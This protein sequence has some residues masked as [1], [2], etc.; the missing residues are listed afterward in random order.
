MGCSIH[1]LFLANLGPPAQ[2]TSL[3]SCLHPRVSQQICVFVDHFTKM[4]YF[5][6]TND[7]DDVEGTVALFLQLVFSP[8]PP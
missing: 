6:L 7:N 1:S 5:A 2:L 3:P 8:W 4:A